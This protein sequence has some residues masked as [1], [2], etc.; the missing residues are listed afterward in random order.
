M[1]TI[2]VRWRGKTTPTTPAQ[3][4]TPSTVVH[5]T[6]RNIR[7]APRGTGGGYGEHGQ[8]LW[9]QYEASVGAF[10]KKNWFMLGLLG[11][12]VITVADSSGITVDPGL[13]LKAHHGPSF[14]IVAIFFLSGLALDTRQIRA[15]L[16]DYKGT[17]L[18]LVLIFLAAPLLALAFSMLPLS[19][20]IVIGLFLVASM[21]S[22]L[23]SGIV[24]TGEAGG[25]MAHA[26]LVTI[27]ANSLAVVTIPI[28]LNALL[29][30]TGDSRVI[31]I[32]QVP[33]MIKIA[34]LVLL[35]LLVG[36]IA[37][38]RTG[39]LLKPLL[40]Y[41]SICNQVGILAIVWMA[42]CQGRDA[43][44]SRLDTMIPVLAVVFT[45]HLVM[46]ILAFT[47]SRFSGMGKGRRE[48]VIFM[49]GQK[50][51][52]LSVVLQVS[53][54]PSYGLAL[55]VCILHHI[56]HLTMDAFLTQRLKKKA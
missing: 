47:V 34:T 11:V 15:G 17:L 2:V 9:R 25:N 33:I 53:L 40:P 10:I 13:W 18:A 49:G 28:T 35:P 23:S 48:S 8:Y 16:A 24:M 41:T 42:S 45:F 5:T 7:I 26:L 46:L 1:N 50:T 52:A 36:L 12:A 55:V 4:V 21:P 51:L 14:I 54:F 22:T 29:A 44:V 37:R 30:F 20:G 6:E 32:D 19:A 31:V 43:I 38:N 56:T 27:V 39:N 3:P